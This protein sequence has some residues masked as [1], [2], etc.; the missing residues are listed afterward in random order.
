VIRSLVILLILS[1]LRY[2]PAE[3]TKCVAVHLTWYGRCQLISDGV[4]S[5]ILKS[6]CTFRKNSLYDWLMFIFITGHLSASAE[7]P[8]WSD[9]WPAYTRWLVQTSTIPSSFSQLQWFKF[10]HHWVFHCKAG[11]ADTLMSKFL[12]NENK[13]KVRLLWFWCSMPLHS[14][15]LLLWNCRFCYYWS[16]KTHWLKPILSPAMPASHIASQSRVIT[17]SGV[18]TIEE[19]Q[20]DTQRNS[21]PCAGE[22]VFK[23]NTVTGFELW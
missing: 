19:G 16:F 21:R 14:W 8:V 2:H 10:W 9:W 18:T 22:N 3:W 5:I 15:M 1:H 6:R 17:V 4:W 20:E 7:Y 13:I 11:K 23:T 12:P